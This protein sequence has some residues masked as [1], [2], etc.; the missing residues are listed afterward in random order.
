MSP[1]FIVSGL[2]KKGRITRNIPYA[3]GVG[4]LPL[5][6]SG[7][8]PTLAYFVLVPDRPRLCSPALVTSSRK[9]AVFWH[10]SGDLS[11]LVPVQLAPDKPRVMGESF[12]PMWASVGRWMSQ[13]TS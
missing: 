6:A 12:T 3:M 5:V 9:V 7:P 13:R 1:S 11:L 8:S 2:G 4:K 10:N